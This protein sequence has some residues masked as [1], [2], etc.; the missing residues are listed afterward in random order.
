MVRSAAP[1]QAEL[2]EA[3]A[4]GAN[5]NASPDDAK[6]RRENHEATIRPASILRDAAFRPLLRMRNPVLAKLAIE[7]QTAFRA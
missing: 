6:H 3:V 4:N 7:Y 2:G 5:K 1:E